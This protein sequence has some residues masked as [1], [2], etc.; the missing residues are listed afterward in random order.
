LSLTRV[1]ASFHRR[2]ALSPAKAEAG[3]HGPSVRRLDVAQRRL[4]ERVHTRPRRFGAARVEPFPFHAPGEEGRIQVPLGHHA[5]VA[6][7][8]SLAEGL[9]CNRPTAVARL[10]QPGR[11]RGELV[12]LPVGACSLTSQVRDELPGLELVFQKPKIR[13]LTPA[14]LRGP[15]PPRPSRSAPRWQ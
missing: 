12:H 14:P 7:V 13:I 2:P 4:E 5:A 9:F 1:H 11:A 6:H 15:R 10:A 8:P 3:R